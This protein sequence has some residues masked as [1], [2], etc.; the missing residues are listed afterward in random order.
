MLFAKSEAEVLRALNRSLAIIEFSATGHIIRANDNF[1]E[2]MGYTSEEIVGKHHRIFVDPAVHSDEDY[3]KFWAELARG[4]FKQAEFK[5]FAKDKRE[6]WLQATYNPVLGLGNRVIKVVKIATDITAIKQRNADFSGQVDAIGRSHAVASFGLDGTILFANDKFL[7]AFG[8]VPDEVLGRHHSMFMDPQ[9]RDS[10]VYLEFWRSLSRGEFRAGKFR[11]IDKSGR[12]VWIE[13]TYNAILDPDGRPFK[14][15]KYATDITR[16]NLIAVDHAGQIEAIHKSQAVIEFGMDGNVLTAN[17]RFLALMGYSIGEIAG[18]HHS[19]FLPDDVEHSKDYRDFWQ[20]LRKGEYQAAQFKRIGKGGHEVW[21]EASY[22]PIMDLDG[23]PLKVVKF[24]TDITEKILQQE[25]LKTLSLVANGTDNSVV[26]TDRNGLIE[27]V[28]RG[29]TRMSGYTAKEV[30][31]RKPGDFLQGKH[32]SPQT[33]KRIRENLAANKSFYEEILNYTKSGEPYW[34]SLSINPVTDED[35]RIERLISVQA[36]I[37]KTKLEALESNARITAIEHA[38]IIF[39]WDDRLQLAKVNRLA[40][41]VMGFHDE[42]LL[43]R[44]DVLQ[45]DR[46][47]SS[48]DQAKLRSGLSLVTNLDIAVDGERHVF[49]SANMQP[50][51]DVEGNLR[52]I[53]VYAVD[54]TARSNAISMMMATVLDQINRTAM[55][56]SSVS[57]QTNLLALNATIE[58]A[59]AGE[60]GRGFGVVAA[61]VKSLARRSASLSTEIAGLVAQTQSKIEDLR[62]A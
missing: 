18:R 12:H 37:T 14:V 50:L 53:V 25:A 7:D 55:N 20:S 34:I 9:E 21:I 62:R 1:L 4:T 39:E 48:D 61:E 2:T 41:E 33:I 42:T 60:A 6:V 17:E 51:R 32:T 36:D 15:V 10:Q 13:A 52:R 22:N 3:L 35:G 58:S 47:V 44:S 19:M 29:F 43:M 5:R 57:A 11:R 31:G 23:R 30:M 26:I 38:N 46:V 24:A 27:Y 59:R 28:N 16:A 8:Y 45:F 40:A 56:I 49:L 54:M